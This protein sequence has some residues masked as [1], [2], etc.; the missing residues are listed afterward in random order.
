IYSAS[1]S[2]SNFFENVFHFKPSR[3]FW[4]VVSGVLSIALM[5]GGILDY[6]GSAM[7]FQGVLLM[8]WAAILVT[9]ALVVK[10]LL[11]IVP[12]EYEA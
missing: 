6:L 3:R 7:T 1:L 8:A 4:V 5:L 9:D 10:K 2:L 12:I 11:K